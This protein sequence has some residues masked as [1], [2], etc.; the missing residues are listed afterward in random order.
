[1]HMISEK[2]WK[3][4]LVTMSTVLSMQVLQEAY[5]ESQR[6]GVRSSNQ[7]FA[8]FMLLMIWFGK[9]AYQPR[10]VSQAIPANLRPWTEM[11]LFAALIL[12]TRQLAL[13]H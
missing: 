8:T 3:W 6:H 13:H 5:F 11:L 9:Y 1:M 10:I 4:G 2:N 7:L 12:M